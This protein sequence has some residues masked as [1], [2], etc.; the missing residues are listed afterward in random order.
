MFFKISFLIVAYL[1]LLIMDNVLDTYE[2]E[3]RLRPKFLTVLCILTFIGSGFGLLS[4]VRDYVQADARAVEIVK[5]KQ[6]MSKDMNNQ[7]NIGTKFVKGMEAFTPENIRKSSLGAIAASILCLVG[8]FMMWKLR[9]TGYYIYIVGVLAGIIVPI[10]LFGTGN[11]LA[12]LGVA[13]S[14][15]FGLLFIV[16]YGLNLKSLR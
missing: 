2:Q 16:L 5:A 9:R 13:I 12:N 1:K 3:P 7:E 6:Q 4:G 15:F 14:G 8:A 11:M 10:A